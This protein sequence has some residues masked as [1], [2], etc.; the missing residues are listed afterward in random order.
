MGSICSSRNE[1]PRSSS[2]LVTSQASSEKQE[3]LPPLS[4]ANTMAF[5]VSIK[6]I[7]VRGSFPVFYYTLTFGSH[8]PIKSG[9]RSLRYMSL[10]KSDAYSFEYKTS[11]ERMEGEKFVLCVFELSSNEQIGQ[12]I[13]PLKTIASGSIHYDYALEGKSERSIYFDIVMSQKVNVVFEPLEVSVELDSVPDS[14]YFYYTIVSYVSSSGPRRQLRETDHH[15]ADCLLQLRAA[16]AG[17][18]VPRR[19][20]QPNRALRLGPALPVYRVQT[21][22]LGS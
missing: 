14:K 20:A 10:N 4:S 17:A 13:I 16:R 15:L 5:D 8:P 9:S 3:S 18:Q 22:P 11:R 6:K 12:V 19:S 2:R 21:H 1:K 7:G